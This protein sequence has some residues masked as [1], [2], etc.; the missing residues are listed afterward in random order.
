[1]PFTPPPSSPIPLLDASVYAALGD[2]SP[3]AR[4]NGDARLELSF[5]A[6][7][8][9]LDVTTPDRALARLKLDPEAFHEVILTV[10]MARRGAGG[11]VLSASER[12]FQLVEPAEGGVVVDGARLTALW[13]PRVGTS[14]PP[15]TLIAH[16]C[17]E[18]G[19][20]AIVIYLTPDAARQLIRDGT[21]LLADLTET[22]SQILAASH[23]SL[24]NLALMETH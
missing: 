13:P 24:A 8:V 1:M 18:Q 7:L 10:A 16:T 2:L 14:T 9:L 3:S 6:G 12:R 5:R 21:R 19:S 17:S 15:L 4:A 11:H 20:L 23:L 22:A